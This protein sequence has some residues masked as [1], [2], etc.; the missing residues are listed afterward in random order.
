MS[1]EQNHNNL[2]E[3]VSS[4]QLRLQPNRLLNHYSNIPQKYFSYNDLCVRSGQQALSQL[5]YAAQ[6]GPNT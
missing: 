4:S 5:C 1:D 3:N 6:S 2:G